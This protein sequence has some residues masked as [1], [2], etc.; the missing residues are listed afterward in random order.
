MNDLHIHSI[1]SD[2]LN[3]PEE[4]ILTGIELDYAEIAICDH[5]RKTTEWFENFCV[6]VERLKY[7]Y[8]KH[9]TVY[10]AVETKV[11]PGGLDIRPEFYRVDLVYAALHNYPGD[12]VIAF[13]TML[14]SKADAIVHPDPEMLPLLLKYKKPVEIN[15]KHPCNLPKGK[16]PLFVGSDSHSVEEMRNSRK[17]VEEKNNELSLLCKRRRFYFL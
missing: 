11:I 14:A 5:V 7:K 6:E 4:I 8:R 12:K 3:T 17:F 10:S 16:F 13:Q 15:F 9:I 2:G 1:Y